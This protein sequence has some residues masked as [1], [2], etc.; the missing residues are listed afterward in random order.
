VS[1]LCRRQKEAGAGKS[2][3]QPV[4]LGL[5]EAGEP[6]PRVRLLA[7][8]PRDGVL[9]RLGDAEGVELMHLAQLARERGRRHAVAD[10]QAGGVQGLAE[11]EHREAALAQL[12]VS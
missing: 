12:R 10:A 3:T 7:Q 4:A 8:I 11:G 5:E 2:R 1:A 6:A 9:Q